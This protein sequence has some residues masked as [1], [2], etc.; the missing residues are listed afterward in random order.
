[1]NEIKVKSNGYELTENHKKVLKVW[2]EKAFEL[3]E[4]DYISEFYYGDKLVMATIKLTDG[5]YGDFNI[6]E[7]SISFNGHTCTNE[8]HSIFTK[9]TWNDE[10][11][12]GILF[13]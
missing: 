9:L 7:K 8:Q 5:H 10:C 11:Y 12:K 2:E 1:M 3:L 4:V 6:T 13:K